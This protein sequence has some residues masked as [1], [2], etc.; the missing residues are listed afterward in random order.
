MAGWEQHYRPVK[1]RDD[2]TF[3]EDPN[4][5]V[6]KGAPQPPVGAVDGLYDT[7]AKKFY[8]LN[9][10]DQVARHSKEKGWK[11]YASNT[12]VR[13][14]HETKGKAP[15]APAAES[16]S[17]MEMDDLSQQMSTM[18]TGS[19][20]SQGSD[21]SFASAYSAVRQDKRG[22]YVS[23]SQEDVPSTAPEPPEGARRALYD[24]ER[25]DYYVQ[26]QGV[27]QRFSKSSS[28]WVSSK[29]KGMLD[30]LKTHGK[31]LGKA[32]YKAALPT[33]TGIAK[34]ASGNDPTVSKWANITSG[35]AGGAEAAYSMYNNVSQTMTSGG[36][37]PFDRFQGA[38]DAAQLLSATG[39]V[40][41]AATA[42]TH[43]GLSDVSNRVATSLSFAGSA[44][45]ATHGAHQEMN[46]QRM[47]ERRE[48]LYSLPEANRADSDLAQH[49]NQN[50]PAGQS[51]SSQP[52]D[53]NYQERARAAQRSNNAPR[54]RSRSR[55]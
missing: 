20:G 51:T 15:A 29:A 40:V 52:V 4:V 49:V 23:A 9:E 31:S 5:R 14:F 2:K 7:N 1:I 8:V 28:D 37:R 11:D 32:G 44:A 17:A 35:V 24:A 39:N 45:E 54:Q 16:S 30:V 10:Q 13:A 18:R 21:E 22:R 41:S 42:H 47:Q 33:A 36:T 3:R 55:G 25:G 43:P 27:L 53:S 6:P 46:A 34:M 48:N 26:N 38:A 19:P 50:L 12:V